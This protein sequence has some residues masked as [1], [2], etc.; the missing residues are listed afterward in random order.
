[1]A[2]S[3]LKRKNLKSLLRE[4]WVESRSYL[5]ESLAYIIIF[6]IILIFNLVELNIVI[7][8]AY[9][10]FGLHLIISFFTGIYARLFHSSKTYNFW[11]INTIHKAFVIRKL[12]LILLVIFVV[13]SYRF[14]PEKNSLIVW[15]V[16][17]ILVTSFSFIVYKAYEII[18]TKINVLKERIS[19]STKEIV[20]FMKDEYF[21]VFNKKHL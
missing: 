3:K 4:L 12:E 19:K 20:D 7:S 15:G 14:L 5:Y 17:I 1:M 16:G 8:A 9:W 18:T 6:I 10:L 21:S 11:K 2:L 13:T